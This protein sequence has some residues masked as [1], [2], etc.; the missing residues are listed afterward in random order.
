MVLSAEDRVNVTS[1]ERRED[2]N[3]SLKWVMILY[4]PWKACNY[5]L[6]CLMFDSVSHF[7]EDCMTLIGLGLVIKL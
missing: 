1:R 3:F 4:K 2:M 7:R 5:E 6:K